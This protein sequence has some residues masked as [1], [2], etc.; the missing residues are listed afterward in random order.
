MK[1]KIIKPARVNL[2]S[3]ECEV[4]KQEADRLFL[5]GLAVCE[6]AKMPEEKIEKKTR[7]K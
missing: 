3:G 1:V 5:L 6:N 2:L 4:T 7:K